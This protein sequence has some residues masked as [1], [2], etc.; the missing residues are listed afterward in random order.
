[1][2]RLMFYTAPIAV[3]ILVPPFL[4]TECRPLLLFLCAPVCPVRCTWATPAT[5]TPETTLFGLSSAS[6]MYLWASC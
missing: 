4:L 6:L 5:R 3:G 1:M 2:L